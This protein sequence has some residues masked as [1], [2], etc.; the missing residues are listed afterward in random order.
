MEELTIK[1]IIKKDRLAEFLVEGFKDKDDIV[2]EV[3]KAFEPFIVEN[4][5]LIIKQIDDG[6]SSEVQISIEELGYETIFSL[7]F[8]LLRKLKEQD[9]K[10]NM[11]S[12]LYGII[13]QFGSF[14]LEQA[15][16]FIL[17]ILEMVE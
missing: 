2:I 5:Y 1:I 4:D 9:D 14:N 10:V 11:E 13:E 17:K 12:L 6:I 16:E 8:A 15:N 3:F 7:V